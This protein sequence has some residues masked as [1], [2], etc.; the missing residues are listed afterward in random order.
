M[1]SCLH[2]PVFSSTVFDGFVLLFFVCFVS[3]R[4]YTLAFREKNLG[5]SPVVHQ[6]KSA[7]SAEFVVDT[8]VMPEAEAHCL[9]A[10]CLMLCVCTQHN[11]L[12]QCWWMQGKYELGL[13]A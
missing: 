1:V 4:V 7:F 5:D 9:L 8:K 10:V 3:P 11:H 2:S 13:C 12:Q 6:N